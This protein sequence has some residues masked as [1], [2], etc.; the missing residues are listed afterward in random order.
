M[1]WIDLAHDMDTWRALVNV[2]MN[3][4]VSLNGGNFLT[5]SGRDRISGRTLLHGVSYGDL[6]PAVLL[7]KPVRWKVS[8]HSQPGKYDVFNLIFQNIFYSQLVNI[9]SS[10]TRSYARHYQVFPI[11][12]LPKGTL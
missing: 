3:I 10:H 12:S 8:T 9:V 11:S 4:L 6:K 5:T 1:D 2:L 7:G